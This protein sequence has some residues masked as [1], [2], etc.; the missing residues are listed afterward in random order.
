MCIRD[1]ATTDDL[2]AKLRRAEVRVRNI[3]SHDGMFTFES[4]TIARAERGPREFSV[5]LTLE[6]EDT[7]YENYLHSSATKALELDW[8]SGTLAGDM[9]QNYGWQMVFP[10]VFIRD[11]DKSYDADG[12]LL[13]HVDAVP[14]EDSDHGVAEA[15]VYN[16]QSAYAA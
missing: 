4:N 1:S 11:V 15:V 6:V 14:M 12:R 3:T 7:T 5:S 2:Q 10:K 9:L 13:L 16:A 8:D